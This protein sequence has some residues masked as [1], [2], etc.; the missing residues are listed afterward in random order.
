M[1]WTVYTCQVTQVWQEMEGPLLE[2]SPPRNICFVATSP[3]MIIR[4]NNVY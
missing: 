2:P 4:M 1:S 3:P